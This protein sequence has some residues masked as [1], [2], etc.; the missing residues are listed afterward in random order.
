MEDGKM[1]AKVAVVQDYGT[2]S[3][4]ASVIIM[5]KAAKDRYKTFCMPTGSTPKGMNSILSLAAR[6]GMVN[7]R[8]ASL[9]HPDEYFGIRRDAPQSYAGII[10]R[11]GA[12]LGFRPENVYLINGENRDEAFN[13][14][15]IERNFLGPEKRTA[16]RTHTTLGIGSK[17]HIAFCERGSPRNGRTSLVKLQQSTI[18]D[19]SKDFGSIDKVPRSAYSLGIGTILESESIMVL[20]NGYHKADAVSAALEGP[21]SSDCPASFLQDQEKALFV[22]DEEAASKLSPNTYNKEDVN[23]SHMIRYSHQLKELSPVLNS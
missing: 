7:L 11:L 20:A 10:G 8:D 2:L 3:R 23:L 16:K 14:W 21:I 5:D 1:K 15:C 13:C 6:S 22:L 12:D 9:K 19:N 4:L 18:I 17:G